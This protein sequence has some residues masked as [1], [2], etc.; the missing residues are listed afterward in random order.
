MEDFQMTN[1]GLEIVFW[2][3]LLT[4][5]GARISKTRKGYKQQY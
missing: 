3:I 5:L 2:L 4:Y 1:L